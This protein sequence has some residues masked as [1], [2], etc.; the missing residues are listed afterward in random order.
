MNTAT[1]TSTALTGPNSQRDSSLVKTIAYAYPTSPAADR[2]GY[3]KGCYTVSIINRITGE[4]LPRSVS[5]FA[6]LAEAKSHAEAISL[7]Y[8]T[9]THREVA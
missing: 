2:F 7:P 6:T 8:S 3:A 4:T 9:L 1:S 5:A